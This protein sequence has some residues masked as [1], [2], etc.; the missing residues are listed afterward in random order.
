MKFNLRSF[1]KL[2]PIFVSDKAPLEAACKCIDK[3]SLYFPLYFHFSKGRRK[4][5]K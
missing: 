3:P 5:K 1:Q 2:K 4:S